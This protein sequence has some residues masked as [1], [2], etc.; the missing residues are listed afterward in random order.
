MRVFLN[1]IRRAIGGLQ[2]RT[3]VLLSGV[4]LAASVLTGALYLR[5]S[6]RL[7]M[8]ETKARAHDVALGLA[9]AAAE[10]IEQGQQRQLL[11][12]VDDLAT[13]SDFAYI[14]FT[15]AKGE[16]LAGHQRGAG[17][18]TRLMLDDPRLFSVQPINQ[19]QVLRTEGGNLCLDV[20]YPVFARP[21]SP[22]ITYAGTVGYVRLGLNL[23]N[24]EARLADLVRN[25]IGLTV[26]ITLLMVPLGYEVVR[27]LVKPIGQ[28][29]EAAGLFAQ[30]HLEARVEADRGDEI[31]ELA[32]SFNAMADQ[33]AKSHNQ[34]VTLNAELEDRVLQRTTALQAANER[35]REMAVRDS[36]TGL[37]N[38][39][40]FADLIEQLNAEAARY[41]TDLT[42]MMLDLDNFKQINDTLGHQIGDRLLQ[43]AA[44]VI[45]RSIRDADV[46]IRF[47]GDEFAVLLPRT[48]PMEAQ[49]SAER[50]REN[51]K[52]AVLRELP[53]AR[54]ASL[55]I[56]LAS[57][58]EDRPIEAIDLVRMAD[59]ALYLAK[60]RG[61]DRITFMG[62]S[63]LESP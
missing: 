5:I 34:L 33:L 1:Q 50:I 27:R 56:G 52:E 16:M 21:T 58:D 19:P 36:L 7:S 38:R 31:G 29:S 57:R 54:T 62:I 30:G 39:R 32:T 61:K 12:I 10:A 51:F 42:C 20:V 41:D 53:L 22:A 55:S 18:V 2:F 46:A 3:T 59:E 4:V 60:A 48:T 44:Q 24:S 45:S 13:G 14:F 23:A 49:A 28:L 9:T 11:R 6:A 35:L 8:A 26:G 40:H 47:G 15:D 25:T 43:L 63:P 17:N 37:Y